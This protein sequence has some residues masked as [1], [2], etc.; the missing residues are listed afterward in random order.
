MGIYRKKRSRTED[1]RKIYESHFGELPLD[2]DGRRFH[3]HHIDGDATNNDISNLVALSI[4][5]H[6]KIHYSQG[7]WAACLLLAEQMNISHTE[8]A[9]MA[10]KHANDRVKNGTHNFLGPEPNRKRIE[11]GTHNFLRREDG[12]SLGKEIS[13]KLVAN[14]THVLL[15]GEIQR[16]QVLDGKNKLVGGQLQRDQ[17]KNGTHPS[18]IKW[19]CEECGKSG[20]GASNEVMHKNKFCKMKIS[21]SCIQ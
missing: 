2:E 9:E 16:K 21:V 17:L 8:V 7:D 6:F 3:I 10:R 5:Q 19:V 12:S 4:N 13:Q 11:E 14:G 15:G 1:Y 20:K 18:Q